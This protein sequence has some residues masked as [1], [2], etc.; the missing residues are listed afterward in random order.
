MCVNTDLSY[1]RETAAQLF[2]GSGSSADTGSVE[3]C[4]CSYGAGAAFPVPASGG[5]LLRSPGSKWPV[6]PRRA[7]VHDGA[8]NGVLCWY[9]LLCF[10]SSP[11]LK[12]IPR[13]QIQWRGSCVLHPIDN[14]M[15]NGKGRAGARGRVCP[16]GGDQQKPAAGAGAEPERPLLPHLDAK[17]PQGPMLGLTSY[18]SICSS[19][20]WLKSQPCY[21]FGVSAV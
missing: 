8:R 9:T 2:L 5:G 17:T 16:R 4:S 20:G 13:H 7:G 1:Q 18:Q 19:K 15:G 6:A 21:C 12:D 14:S 11:Q 3:S 10:H